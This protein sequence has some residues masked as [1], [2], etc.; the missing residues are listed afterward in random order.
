M[1][2]RTYEI[3]TP[4]GRARA[5]R[6]LDWQDHDILR[7]RWHNFEEVATGV[8]RSNQPSATRFQAYADLGI[9]TI[10]NLR[11][12]LQEP[13]F[14]FE[15]E[16]CD[17]IGLKIVSIGL[18]ARKAPR[19][20]RLLMLVDAFE[21]MEKPFLIHCKSGADRTGLA[22][23]LYLL[24]YSDADDD[25]LRAQLSFRY[26]HIRKSSTGIL[27][28]FLETYLARRQHS[29]IGLR[30]WIVAEY[31]RDRMMADYQA[32]KASETFWEGW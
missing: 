3:V 32:M 4:Q 1:A 20:E 8:Y 2:K 28:F 25:T 15:Q 17:A 26:L 5:R 21:T 18:S 29:P 16:A 30:D 13:F 11:G 10:L 22:S 23:A 24:L 6:Q 9:K 31:D 12:P 14:L 19:Q 7:R 27:D